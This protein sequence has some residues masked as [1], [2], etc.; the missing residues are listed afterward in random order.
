P[1]WYIGLY[2]AVIG[3]LL[4]TTVVVGVRTLPPPPKTI[5]NGVHTRAV[6]GLLPFNLEDSELFA[7]LELGVWLQRVLASLLDPGFRFGILVG[8]SGS[9][10]T[11]FLRA[12]L[13]AQLKERRV[14]V[15]YVEF[16][17]EEPTISI[18]RE[19]ARQ[20]GST[21]VHFLLLDHFEQFFLHQRT[22]E[23]RRP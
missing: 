13:L 7:Q 22:A 14:S 3:L 16:S 1:P 17:N 23:Q 12:G 10:K 5:G 9:G 18:N 19:L 21:G 20:D 4:I 11:S 15:A 8:P 6:R 2:W